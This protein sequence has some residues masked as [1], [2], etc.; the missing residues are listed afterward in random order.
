MAESSDSDDG[1]AP[2]R[3]EDFFVNAP[4]SDGDITPPAPAAEGEDD[5]H[6]AVAD[7]IGMTLEDAEPASAED[8]GGE[9]DGHAN[10]DGILYREPRRKPFTGSQARSGTRS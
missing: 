8:A 1:A 3:L 9:P 5:D 6:L 2:S 10:L 4:S 7:L